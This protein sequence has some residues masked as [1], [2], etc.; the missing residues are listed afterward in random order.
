MQSK[1]QPW[2]D[3]YGFEENPLDRSSVV[4]SGSKSLI[5]EILYRI[6]AKSMLFIEGAQGSGKSTL[7][8]A[9]IRSF[10]GRIIYVDCARFNKRFDI[11][12]LLRNRYGFVK[13]QILGMKPKRMILML[14]NVNHLTRINAERLKYY[15]DSD[16]LQ[17][18]IF[19]GERYADA[20]FDKGLRQRIGGRVLRMPGF[21][22]KE[23]LPM[24][25][26]RCDGV[27]LSSLLPHE[28]FEQMQRLAG[29]NPGRML[30]FMDT[31]LQA[32]ADSGVEPAE[33]IKQH[34][35]KHH[36]LQRIFDA[37]KDAGPEHEPSIDSC[38]KCGSNML[39]IGYYVRCQE[40][41]MCCSLCGALV[42]DEN[43]ALCPG[44]NAAFANE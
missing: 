7:L 37:V 31:V 36:S 11:E 13:G 3:R 41:D 19:T 40:C 14:D 28:A 20:P 39:S 44:C 27:D 30:S 21:T 6:N 32:A 8:R 4:W 24:L 42:D 25:N 10:R 26:E 17:S 12:Q 2:Y 1:I 29:G 18:V 22:V 23:L 16:Y 15:F 34:S 9:A 43:A 33:Y 35:I 38:P 5:D